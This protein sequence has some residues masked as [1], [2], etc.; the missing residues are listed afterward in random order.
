MH[1]LDAK[2]LLGDEEPRVSDGTCYGSKE[3]CERII[4][5]DTQRRALGLDDVLLTLQF[6][7]LWRRG[8]AAR[9][10]QAYDAES[11][12]RVLGCKGEGAV[13][14]NAVAGEDGLSFALAAACHVAQESRALLTPQRRIILYDRLG[15]QSEA[16][17]INGV[18]SVTSGCEHIDV[19]APVEARRSKA[20]D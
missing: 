6:S 1:L 2:R 17:E 8:E 18:H 14:A 15:A 3:L 20:V 13:S 9:A 12:L 5:S 10:V 11:Q 16:D 19:S 4:Q 7:C